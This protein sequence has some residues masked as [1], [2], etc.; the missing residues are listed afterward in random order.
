[1]DQIME[2]FIGERRIIHVVYGID[3]DILN[4]W[5]QG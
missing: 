4:R 5:R 1:M 3:I 2:I